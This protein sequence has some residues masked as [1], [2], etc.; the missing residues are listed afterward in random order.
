MQLEYSQMLMWFYNNHPDELPRFIQSVSPNQI[1]CKDWLVD[2]L[3]NVVIPRDEDGKFKVEI[4]GG[5]FGFPLIQMLCE[6][7]GSDIKGIDFFEMDPFAC[8]VLGQY[9][10]YM[11]EDKEVFMGEK[12]VEIEY[13]YST[14][15]PIK[16][17]NENYFEYKEKRRAH[18]IINTSCEHMHPMENAREF[19]IE[20]ERTLLVL[21]SNDK[22][23][24]PDHIN[25]VKDGSD[26][27]KQAGIKELYGDR[28]QFVSGT[29]PDKVIEGVMR[30]G[31]MVWWNRFMVMGKWK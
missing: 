20:P 31:D 8:R 13:V 22:D 26:L 30:K 14:L 23:D 7:R 29:I 2:S 24:E 10:R 18:M 4:V 21:Q 27:S 11:K 5:W 6:R 12:G 16:I 25:C 1:K 3:S 15:P 19:Y 17:F 28:K 9:I